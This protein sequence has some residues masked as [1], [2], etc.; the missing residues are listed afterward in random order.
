MDPSLL[1]KVPGIALALPNEQS[2]FFRLS[3]ADSA[4][5]AMTDLRLS[6]VS[7][8]LP[9]SSIEAALSKMKQAGVR[10]LFVIDADGG[11]LGSITSHDIQGE[12]PLQFMQSTNGIRA[13]REILVQY[14]MEPMSQWRVLDFRHLQT[15][16]VG[17]VVTLLVQAGRR[18]LVVVES[19]PNPSGKLVRGLFSA[20]RIQHLLGISIDIEVRPTTFAEIE[21]LIA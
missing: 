21:R 9:D 2:E 16:T 14:V 8:T 3:R 11:L 12:K 13:W 5:R 17:D 6:P 4:V 7:T 18:H 10:F 15:L 20:S 1:L 19:A